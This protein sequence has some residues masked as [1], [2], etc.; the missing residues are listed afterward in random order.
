MSQ[1][2]NLN[3]YPLTPERWVDL[4]KLFGEKGACGGCWCMYWRLKRSEFKQ[5]KGSKNKEALKRLVASGE[6]PG[7][8]AFANGEPVGWCSVA[9][10]ESFPTLERSRVLERVDDMPVWSVVCLFVAKPFRRKGV[11]SELLRA[12]VDHVRKLGGKIVE[13]YPVEPKT[14]LPDPFVYTG[15][16]TAFRKAGFTEVLRRSKTRPIMRFS[17]EQEKRV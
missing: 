17:I 1:I 10:R 3:F 16:V 6:I 5:G 8:L 4:E 15:L 13:G 11:S 7:V 2:P 12:A 9:P 14:M